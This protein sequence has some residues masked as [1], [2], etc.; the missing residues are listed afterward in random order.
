MRYRL[1]NFTEEFLQEE[2]FIFGKHKTAQV[3]IGSIERET[4]LSFGSLGGLDPLETAT[5]AL[6]GP[7]APLQSLTQIRFV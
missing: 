4:G 3:S 1:R 7:V 6:E 2:E 5:E